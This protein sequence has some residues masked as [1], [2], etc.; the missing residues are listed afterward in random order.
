MKDIQKKIREMTPE[1][2]NSNY[3]SEPNQMENEQNNTNNKNPE[4]SL[5]ELSSIKKETPVQEQDP[6]YYG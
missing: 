1:E 4:D 5:Q 3:E 2:L 6:D